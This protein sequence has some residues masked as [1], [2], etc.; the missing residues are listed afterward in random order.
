MPNTLIE[1]MSVGLPIA[2]SDRGP[3][4]EVLKQ[5][6]VYFNPDSPLSIANAIE[7]YLK[8]ELL[9]RNNAKNANQLSINYSWERCSRETIAFLRKVNNFKKYK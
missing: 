9:V 4:P 2:C 5:S 8:D 1:A 7:S 3:M 6:G